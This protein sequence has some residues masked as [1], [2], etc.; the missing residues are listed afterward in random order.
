MMRVFQGVAIEKN[1]ELT[2]TFP[3][4]PLTDVYADPLR[5]KQVL[6]NLLSNA[7]KFTDIGSVSL[8]LQQSEG[9]DNDS[10]HYIIDVQDSGVGIDASQ[11]AALFRPF[12]QAENRRRN[13]ASSISV[14]PFAKAWRYAH[15]EQ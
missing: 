10:V 15:A 14:G 7:I 11:Q 3:T 5:I 13:W 2:R 12:S 4:E 8:T 9:P 6:S 1:I